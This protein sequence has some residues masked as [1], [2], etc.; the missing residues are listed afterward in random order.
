MVEVTHAFIPSTQDA[1]AGESM[2]IPGQSGLYLELK[3]NQ[4]YMGRPCLKHT[5]ES[6][7]MHLKVENGV[8]S[9]ISTSNHY[10]YLSERPQ[11]LKLF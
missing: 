4:G 8:E 6:K 5:K 3:G 11:N 1:E 10:P 9:Q 7:T 2:L